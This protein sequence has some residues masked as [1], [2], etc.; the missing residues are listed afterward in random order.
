MLPVAT[1]PNAIVFSATKMNP[2][3][4]VRSVKN[5]EKNYN[6]SLPCILDESRFRYEHCLR[7][8]HLL[9]GCFARQRVL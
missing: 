3:E 2:V 9:S 6:L 1:P 7:D 5:K 8:C 4:M